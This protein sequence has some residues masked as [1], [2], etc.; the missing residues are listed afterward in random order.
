VAEDE[1]GGSIEVKD[2]LVSAIQDRDLAMSSSKKKA[3]DRKS[4]DRKAT[5]SA[6]QEEMEFHQY[7]MQKIAELDK[8][9]KHLLIFSN[10][11]SM[12]FI[13]LNRENEVKAWVVLFH[14][15]NKSPNSQIYDT[16]ESFAKRNSNGKK[17]QG[18][19]KK[20]TGE[21]GKIT[22]Q[23]GYHP[24]SGKK[25]EHTGWP[26]DILLQRGQSDETKDK[27]ES[28]GTYFLI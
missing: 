1:D 12:N 14:F 13:D 19:F 27:P 9:D 26:I 5:D 10:A 28:F 22:Y 18:M 11:N 15:K 8:R 3:V 4:Y 23:T 25:C 17:K 2:S 21:L 16:F 20:F 6:Y 7:R 24:A